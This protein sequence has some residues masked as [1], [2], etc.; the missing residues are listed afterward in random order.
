[1]KVRLAKSAGFCVGV[2]RAIDIAF[3][4]ASS[5][6]KV[7]ML[8]DIVHNEEVVKQIRGSGIKKIEKIREQVQ[9]VE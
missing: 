9:N 6:E 5:G 4:A 8:G 2:K 1:M 3:K 7:C